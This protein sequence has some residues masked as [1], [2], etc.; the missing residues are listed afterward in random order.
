VEEIYELVVRNGSG[1]E[2]LVWPFEFTDKGKI[3]Y[4]P[5]GRVIKDA[6]KKYKETSVTLFK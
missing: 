6:I 1:D 2:V 5:A 3:E 4:M